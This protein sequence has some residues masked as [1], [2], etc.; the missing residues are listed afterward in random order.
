MLTTDQKGAVAELAIAREAINLGLDVYRPVVEGGRYD[1]IIE[2]GTTLIR[3]Q[4][5]W[6]PRHGDVVTVRCYS[7]RRARDGLRKRCYVAEEVDAIAAYCEDVDRCF[8][9]PSERFDGHSQLALRLGP[10]RNNQRLGINWADDF[11]L[12]ARLTAL[13]GP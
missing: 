2:V 7:S 13:V 4:C 11:D 5:K 1:L 3:T 6:A 10:S 12:D 9:V 8:F